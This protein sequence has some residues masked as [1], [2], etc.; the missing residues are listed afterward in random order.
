MNTQN[1]HRMNCETLERRELLT[2]KFL[3]KFDYSP[4]AWEVGDVAVLVSSGQAGEDDT[5]W[6]LD[7]TGLS[8]I[9]AQ[10][11]FSDIPSHTHD[12]AV[13]AGDQVF[14]FPTIMEGHREKEE[15]WV[16]DGTQD[17]T[18]RVFTAAPTARVRGWNSI[19]FDNRLYFPQRD[20][21]W[22]SDGT[23]DGTY[24]VTDTDPSKRPCM[25]ANCRV[26]VR[27]PDVEELTEFQGSLYFSV[28]K[29]DRTELWK[30]DG[31][32]EGTQVVT[33][34]PAETNDH[35]R[36]EMWQLSVQDDHLLL[37]NNQGGR[38]IS[39]GSAEG[40]IQLPNAQ[41]DDV[42]GV[43]YFGEHVLLLDENSDDTYALWVETE[44]G[45]ELLKSDV[46]V[47][48]ACSV[49]FKHATMGDVLFFPARDTHGAPGLWKTDGTIAGTELVKDTLLVPALVAG[50]QLV[51][52]GDDEDSGI[53]L[54][55][56]DGTTAGTIRI[57]D[58]V[59]GPEDSFAKNVKGNFYSRLYV[60]HD[61]LYFTTGTPALYYFGMAAGT[62]MDLWR[63]PLN[64]SVDTSI[65][66]AIDSLYAEIASE[67]YAPHLDLVDDGKLDESD[68]QFLVENTLQTRF[69]DANLDGLVDF[70]D[71]LQLSSNYGLENSSW[72]QGDF[73]GNGTVNFEDFLLLSNN[74]GFEQGYES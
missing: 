46:I 60:A 25:R 58:M 26:Y 49:Q 8:Q 22:V 37:S 28:W 63:L 31:T 40:T 64:N 36:S 16:T 7:D 54:W 41:C 18:N 50:D 11:A 70:S 35:G 48:S 74:F 73:D 68:V 27:D 42:K 43:I 55:K 53:E 23:V 67:T 21:L 19:V 69:G 3:G 5:I 29:T 57:T 71:F 61:H 52:W 10:Q 32:A 9:A 38:W 44:S 2:A 6:R 12:Q 15:I 34:I 30:S 17:G 65:G 51:L 66:N 39:D 45:R 13:V 62:G 56:T 72:S 4:T 33:T 1:K 14:F 24:L 59:A 47:H 20:E